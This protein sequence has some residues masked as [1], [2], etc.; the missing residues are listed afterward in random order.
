MKIGPTTP[1]G[2]SKPNRP[3]VTASS[4]NVAGAQK[5]CDNVTITDDARRR[6]SQLAAVARDELLGQDQADG[7]NPA[8]DLAGNKRIA[9]VKRR[10]EEGYYGRPEI[11]EQI[12][13]HLADD[14]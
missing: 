2:A 11:K 9:E 12:A 1:G 14:V 3:A 6:L 5:H 10:I 8:R 7:G 4:D 13:D